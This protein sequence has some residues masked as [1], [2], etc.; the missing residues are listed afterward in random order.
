MGIDKFVTVRTVQNCTYSNNYFPLFLIVTFHHKNR[1][2][3]RRLESSLA[4]AS[5][6]KLILLTRSVSNT[7]ESIRCGSDVCL[8]V[9]FLFYLP[10]RI[11]IV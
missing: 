10:S 9:E 11:I 5:L 6:K 1:S 3:A 8:I 2:I 4:P 7:T